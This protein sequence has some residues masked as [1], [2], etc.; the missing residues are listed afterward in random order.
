MTAGKG[1]WLT[2]SAR[3][4]AGF[5]DQPNAC[6]VPCTVVYG[7]AGILF[8]IPTTRCLLCPILHLWQKH[9][10]DASGGVVL[11]VGARCHIVYTREKQRT[12]QENLLSR[13]DIVQIMKSGDTTSLTIHVQ[14][15]RK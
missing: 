10:P 6:T 11:R 12:R 15:R 7:V 5:G 3:L 1:A 8:N 14:T 13:A 2:L 9:S 4:S